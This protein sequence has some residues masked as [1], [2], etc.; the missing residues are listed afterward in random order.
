[1]PIELKG[2][3]AST[4]S[5]LLKV[6]LV[7]AKESLDMLMSLSVSTIS[8]ELLHKAI[9]KLVVSIAISPMPLMFI[10]PKK[11]SSIFSEILVVGLDFNKVLPMLLNSFKELSGSLS[12]E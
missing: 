4:S 1:M 7:L 9:E 8:L 2:G 11:V 12:S 3:F 6:L 10:L 5:S